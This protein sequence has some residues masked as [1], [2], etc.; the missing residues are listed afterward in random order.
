VQ[1][2]VGTF[3]LNNLFSR[4]D[5]RA[6]VSTA[7]ASTVKVEGRTSNDVGAAGHELG[8]RLIRIVIPAPP[9]PEAKAPAV[10]TVKS[11]AEREIM[12]VSPSARST[13]VLA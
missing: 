11:S 12:R 3:N 9:H 5:F 10:S 6:D 1:I 8:H 13:K 7:T 4:F 2:A